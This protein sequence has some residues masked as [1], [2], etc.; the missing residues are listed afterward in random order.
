MQTAIVLGKARVER[1][2]GS[3]LALNCKQLLDS[4][5][6]MPRNDPNKEPTRRGAEIR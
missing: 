3:L 4:A 2:K 1:E 6:V 5:A